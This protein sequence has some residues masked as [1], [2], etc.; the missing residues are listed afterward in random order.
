[1]LKN[2]K[3]LHCQYATWWTSSSSL[4]GHSWFFLWAMASFLNFCNPEH[5]L[6]GTSLKPCS[7]SYMG[8]MLIVT[9][10][11]PRVSTGFC[12]EQTSLCM[13]DYNFE[14]RR[15]EL[16]DKLLRVSIFLYQRLGHL[17]MKH[18]IFILHVKNILFLA[19][20]QVQF[21]DQV[22]TTKK[23]KIKQLQTESLTIN[24]CIPG[25]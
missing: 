18:A 12:R 21:I 1:M 24:N 10:R 17:I 15:S 3:W 11:Y 16:C 23:Q 25:P 19:T 20:T 5:T 8:V 9:S 4:C 7:D 13:K 14:S 2:I 22:Y 6:E